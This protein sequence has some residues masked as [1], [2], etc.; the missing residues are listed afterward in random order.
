MGQLL[1]RGHRAHAVPNR[2]VLSTGRAWIGKSFVKGT[3]ASE[4]Q[5][6]RVRREGREDSL[7]RQRR[8]CQ[9]EAL[10]SRAW[11]GQVTKRAKKGEGSRRATGAA[12][13][14]VGS[15]PAGLGGTPRTQALKCSGHDLVCCLSWGFVARTEVHCEGPA[16][17]GGP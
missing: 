17:P 12:C 3:L 5:P 11:L 15:G 7:A 6:G 13:P 1:H 4:T 9:P 10:P 2:V 14:W 8:C 16:I